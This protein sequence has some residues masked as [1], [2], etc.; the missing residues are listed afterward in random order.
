MSVCACVRTHADKHACPHMRRCGTHH[1]HSTLIRAHAP[2]VARFLS[3]VSVVYVRGRSRALPSLISVS[4]R[5][6]AFGTIGSQSSSPS[7]LVLAHTSMCC[8]PALVTMSLKMGEGERILRTMLPTLQ[9]LNCQGP[10]ACVR[11]RARQGLGAC[12]RTRPHTAENLPMVCV[13]D[14]TP[15]RRLKGRSNETGGAPAHLP[16]PIQLRHQHVARPMRVALDAAR[17]DPQSRLLGHLTRAQAR[18]IKENLFSTCKYSAQGVG[19]RPGNRLSRRF[20]RKTWH[21]EVLDHRACA[22]E[23][24]RQET[25]CASGPRQVRPERA[26]AP[27]LDV[28]GRRPRRRGRAG[29][30]GSMPTDRDVILRSIVRLSCL[31]YPPR[32]GGSRGTPRLPR[33][34]IEADLS[35]C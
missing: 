24:G 31:P 2:S 19:L 5:N 27:M 1:E 28:P 6:T 18:E 32:N 10:G 11:A 3:P 13:G 14:S 23:R 12:V 8:D 33:V 25:S 7:L 17:Q 20:N 29:P 30:R 16:G 9:P 22:E 34:A 26:R 4:V 35:T 21:K 15:R